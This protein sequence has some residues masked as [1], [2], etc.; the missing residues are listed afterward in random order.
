MSCKLISP[1]NGKDSKLIDKLVDVFKNEDDAKIAYAKLNGSS[2]KE[3]FGNWP[4]RFKDKSFVEDIGLVDEKTGEPVLKYN[5]SI[6]K[7]YFTLP[8][9]EK[10]YLDKM[11][12][13]EFSPIQIE[14]I[15]NRLLYRFVSEGGEASLNNFDQ[16]ELKDGLLM[17]SIEDSIAYF[18]EEIKGR[19]HEEEYSRRLDLI[20]G[21]KLDFKRELINYIGRLGKKV[22]ERITDD[23]GNNINEVKEEDRGGGVNIKDSFETN[24]KESATVNTKI[25]LHQIEERAVEV[26]E[27]G[28]LTG[29]ITAVVDNY[30]GFPAFANFN[31]TWTTLN[32]ILKDEVGYGHGE[33]VHDIFEIMF[34]KIASYSNDEGKLWLKDLLNK[35]QFYKDS[36]DV[37]KINEFVQAFNKTEL[38]FFVTQINDKAGYNVINATATNSRKNQLLRKWDNFFSNRFLVNGK[39]NSDNLKELREYRSILEE[40]REEFNSGVAKLK[41]E[42]RKNNQSIFEGERKEELMEVATAS[43]NDILEILGAIGVRDIYPDDVNRLI[44]MLGGSNKTEDVF[45]N[46]YDAMDYMFKDITSGKFKFL[47]KNGGL[48]NIFGSQS[49]IRAFADAVGYRETDIAEASVL[50]TSGKTGYS[51][52]NPTYLSNKINEWKKDKSGLE[53]LTKEASNKNSVWINYLLASE[54]EDIDERKKLSDERLDN[55]KAGLDS[56]FKSQGKNDGVS[57]T[58]ITTN[59]NI[60]ANIAQMLNE[61]LGG[62]SLFPTIIAADKSRRILFSGL[63]MQRFSFSFNED[64]GI[65]MDKG[66]IDIAVGYAEDEYRRIKNVTRENDDPDVEKIVHYHGKGKNGTKFQIFPEFNEDNTDPELQDLRDILYGENLSGVDGFTPSQVEIVAK[67]VEKSINDRITEHNEKISNLDGLSADLLKEYESH[68][69]LAGNYFINGLVSSVEYTKLFSGDPAY[70]KSTEDLIKRIPATYTDGLQL[71]LRNSDELIFNQATVDGV[72]VAS[73]YVEKIRESVKDKSIAKAYDSNKKGEG[74]VN[75]TD[76]QAWI[77]PRRWRFLK[78]GLGQWSTTHD[79]VFDKMMNGE[80]LDNPLHMKLAAQPLKGVYFEINDGRPVYLKYSQAVLI[81]SLVKGTPMEALYNKMTKNPE[82][83]ETWGRDE[84]HKEIHEVITIDGIKVGSAATTPLNVKGTTDMLPESE[85]ELNPV[86]LNNRGWKLQQDLPTKLMHQTNVGSQIQ[87]NILEG[88]DLKAMYGD[89]TGA[90]LLKEIHETVSELS[91]FGKKELS[92]RFGIN[93]EGAIKNPTVLYN[94]LIQEFKDRGGN[95]NIVTALEKAMALDGLPQIRGKVE[96]V[97]MSIFNKALTKISTQGGSFIQVSP[98]GLEK[99]GENSS[100]TIVSKNYNKE[101]LLPPRIDKKTGKVLPGQAMIPHTYALQLL[102]RH[103]VDIKGKSIEEAVASLDPSA[104]EMITYRIPNQGMSSNDYLEIV[105]ILPPGVG[106]SIVVYDGLPA[107]TGSDF[108]IDKLF[109]M[110]NHLVMDPETLKLTKLTEENRHILEAAG[111]SKDSIDKLLAENKLVSLYKAVLNSPHTYDNMMRSIDGAQLQDDIAGPKGNSEKGLFPAPKMGNMELFSPLKQLQVKSEYL[112]GKFGVAQTANQLVDH[113]SN[114]S[115]NIRLNKWLGVGN[116]RT[117]VLDSGKEGPVTF[118]DT[119]TQD[120][121]SIADNLSAFLNA[122]VDIAKDPY[123]SRGNHNSVTANATFM[124]I[125]AGVPLKWV[126]RFIG[127]PILKELVDLQMEQQSITAQNLS[128]GE[129]KEKVYVNPMESIMN[130]YGF[131]KFNLNDTQH[132]KEISEIDMDALEKNIK[133]GERNRDLDYQVLK[134]WSFLSEQAKFFNKG[135]NAAKSDTKGAGGSNVDRIVNNN[136]I[137]EVFDDNVLRGYEGK[138]NGTMLSTYRENTLNWVRNVIRNSE[139]FLSG[140]QTAEDSYNLISFQT[141][142]GRWLTNLDLAKTIDNN[143]YSYLMSG[144]S[145]FQDNHD[146]YDY[147]IREFPEKIAKLQ[148][149]IG[150]DPEGNF[151]IK[152]LEIEQRNKIKYLGINNKNKPTQYQNDMYRAWMKLYETFYEN[153]DGSIDLDNL[154]PERE[155]AID[156][157]KY[158][159]STSGFQNNLA[160]FFTLIPHQILKEHNISKYINDEF[161]S[162]ARGSDTYFTDQLQRHS[163][164]D[165]NVVKSVKLSD[166]EGNFAGFIYSPSKAKSKELGSVDKTKPINDR[167][168]FPK[169]VSSSKSGKKMLFEKIGT[170]ERVDSENVKIKVP[171][172]IRTFSLGSKDGKYRT[173]EYSKNENIEMSKIPE[174]NPPQETRWKTQEFISK[175]NKMDDFVPDDSFLAQT[176]TVQTERTE[177]STDQSLIEDNFSDIVKDKKIECK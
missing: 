154:T 118:F 40:S 10:D 79:E 65:E 96:S 37:N 17:R 89:M 57:N 121:H 30:L 132:A 128:I 169:F 90:Q 46:L 134:A 48:E 11:A 41:R 67:H 4:K 25:M 21:S 35:L 85:I 3:R 16:A 114:Q 86:R 175:V 73:R 6:N 9:G 72:E 120:T 167:R 153:E 50:L 15:T 106:D 53:S 80:P 7:W 116:K 51:I 69:N 93:S 74:G 137:Q 61:A 77:T 2:F 158:S 139:L 78:K 161:R 163:M 44:I 1:A 147:L 98:F 103:G 160:Q 141:S 14:D 104:L 172:Y 95:E 34:D 13:S 149:E 23:E 42:A 43:A 146:D 56:S 49:Y 162:D 84:G 129:G 36:N 176:E 63:P 107:K 136:K 148:E 18:R 31:D 123:I 117:E 8:N 150:D 133:S 124:L 32:K 170:V 165:Y 99:V 5:R 125:R 101:G 109:A 159:F 119:E 122:Y 173:F 60:N 52:S 19:E 64:G 94:V 164:E 140:T 156:L 71:R 174:N 88:L 92:K 108:D 47:T 145:L 33:N 138:F 100:I 81:P 58:E 97:F 75:T 28:N 171:V 144:L 76:A 66:V 22:N 130:S 27:D 111:Q 68:I 152:E 168:Y 24:S 62:E 20:E 151:L 83:G 157:A 12:L 126:N 59:D 82:T 166:M 113:V 110:Q 102:K 54:E 39:L 131:E 45:T 115:L 29:K 135:V 112:S 105:G 55:L 142:N 38:N 143:F 127:Q 26:D 70:Y 87:K 177:S 91:N 155:L